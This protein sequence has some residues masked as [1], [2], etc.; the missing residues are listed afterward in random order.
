MIYF[1]TYILQKMNKINRALMGTLIGIALVYTIIAFI[2]TV[3]L[4]D[5]DLGIFSDIF[6]FFTAKLIV[7][8]DPIWEFFNVESDSHLVM[9]ILTVGLLLVLFGCISRPTWNLKGSDDDPK[10]YLFTHRPKA[11]F[12][13]LMIPWNILTVF[14]NLKKVPVIIPILFVPFMLPFALVADLFLIIPFLIARSIMTLRINKAAKKDREIYD[15]DTQY[16]VCPTCKRNFRQPKIK[17]SCGLVYSYPVPSEYGVKYHVCN[18]GHWMPS[19]NTDG[20]RSK[21]QAVCPHCGGDMITHEAKPIVVSM[22]GTVGSG[23]TTMMISAV[24][25]ITAMAKERGI[26]SDVITEGISTKAQ[27]GKNKVLPTRSGELDSEYFFLRARDFPEK[28]IVIND[29]SGLEFMP[30][31]EKNLF[32]EYYRYNN[33]II[34]AVDPLEVMALHHSQSPTKGSKNTPTASLESFYHMFTEINGYGPAVKSDVPFAIVLTKM[35][36]PRVKSA[37]NAEGSPL[38]FLNKYSHKMMVDIAQSAF[39]NVKY[40]KVASFGSDNNAM[41]PFLWILS[42]NDADLKKR[43]S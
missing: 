39:K 41:E 6:T 7:M 9:I 27:Y 20:V 4:P 38:S 32:E 37:V 2:L 28:Q 24:E 25:S 14:W 42:E 3:L 40:F 18:N 29:I 19:N 8:L 13:C 31:K 17:C 5:L 36:D 33:G 21:L 16:A 43:L 15:R 12:W 22:I 11:L 34:L 35:D 23:K 30:D 1:L 10:I 26:V